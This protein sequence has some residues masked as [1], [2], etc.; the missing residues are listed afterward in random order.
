VKRLLIFLL[1]AAVGGTASFVIW[2]RVRL[3]RAQAALQRSADFAGH[4]DVANAERELAA[5]DARLVDARRYTLLKQA[6]AERKA[7]IVPLVFDRNG[8]VIAAMH[9]AQLV[10]TDPAFAPLIDRDAG[11]LTIGANLPRLGTASTL[12]TTLDPFTQH[13]A[14]E[15]LGTHRGALVAIDPRTNEILA[16]A[17]NGGGDIALERQFEPGSVVKVLTGLN[18]L[19]G[20]ADVKSM[21]PY[22]CK[23][24]LMIDGR[25]F[26]DWVESGHGRLYSIDDAL[27]VSCNVFFA[28]VGLRIGR[29]RLQSFMCAA[30][31][32]TQT[33]LGYVN[34]P[35][36][37][38]VGVPAPN[39][40][41]AFY[42]I[43]LAHESINAIHLAMLAS[44]MANRGLLMTPRFLRAR[45]TILGDFSYVAPAKT[46][47]RLAPVAAAEMMVSAMKAVAA[48][49]R[50]TGRRAQIDGITLAMKTG[51][52]GER[53]TGLDAL[54]MAFAPAESPRIAF[55]IIA[56]D[57][58]PA[59]YAGAEIAKKFLEAVK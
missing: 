58:G 55:G 13:V 20:A 23:G 50:G 9:G 54:I 4:G 12:D 57:A 40:E 48:N 44:M 16:I 36:G 17:S 7:G 53:K 25:H 31:F 30:G 26:G 39:F 47:R 10:A 46:G 24:E 21:F 27:A 28:D 33:S 1:V 5:I 45:R 52:A 22:T 35:L 49:P 6:I 29:E 15:A 11:T 14:L 18:A 8:G 3:Q 51:T 42:A 2:K 56:E 34:V 41:T 32:D 43:G 37:R 38:S 19:S 59:E